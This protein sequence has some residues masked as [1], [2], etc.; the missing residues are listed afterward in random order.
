MCLVDAVLLDANAPPLLPGSRHPAFFGHLFM[1]DAAVAD[2]PL[3]VAEGL[4]R[5]DRIQP[6]HVVPAVR[7]VLADASVLF[8]KLEREIT[9]AW[10]AAVEA[11]D[12]L[13]IPFQYAWSPVSHLLGV[14]NS[15]E[16][17]TAHEEVLGEVVSFGLRMGQSKPAYRALKGLKQGSEW[18]TLSEAQ[19]RIVDH[20]ILD[21]EL[22]GI[23]LSGEPRERFNAIVRELSQLSTD[24]SNHVLDATKAFSIV[25][26]ER[27]DAEGLPE[28][29]L[30]LG[31]H[32][33]N[34]SRKEGEAAG[35]EGTGRWR[36][37]L[38]QPSY[39]PFLQ[40]R[41]RR[42]L[43]ETMYRAYV[44][45]ASS[46]P[47]DNT[48]LVQKILSLR[49]EKARLLG[50]ETFAELSLAKKMAPSVAAVAEMFETLR[51][52]SWS[53]G[54]RELD[55]IRSLAAPEGVRQPLMNW[56]VPFWA[57]RLRERKF[58]FTEEELRPFFPLESVLEG[59]F[60][61]AQRLFGVRVTPADGEAPVWHP[62]VRFFHVSDE[63]G[64]RIASF[65]LDP[66]SRPEN[67]RG[68]AWMDDGLGRARP[69]RA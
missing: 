60:G 19:R 29:L 31:S 3:L 44:T 49:A 21:A 59:L 6:A 41:R 23:A 39:G 11:L 36:F 43:R 15:P 50:F 65:Y 48:P 66:Y 56:D 16:L 35:D 51:R 40:H 5:F 61:L 13:N 24:F 68:G 45:R 28:S 67:K 33:Y 18:S 69:A 9:P 47:L 10:S 64:R 42:D 12:E 20:K 2:N 4:P 27:A 62:D 17:R 53:A 8:D 38:E 34:T 1:A 54:Q 55:E 30:R 46:G 63:S 7:K 32:S 52:A 58:Q 25:L 26:T 37:T 22:S 14:L 57:E